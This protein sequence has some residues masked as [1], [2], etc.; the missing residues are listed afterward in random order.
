MNKTVYC[1][2]VSLITL[3]L[4]G[5]V[6]FAQKPL[7]VGDVL[8]NPGEK[9][10]GFIKVPKGMDG[11]EIQLPI[12]IINGVKDGPVLALTAGIHGYEYPPILALQRLLKQVEPSQI[13]GAVIMV[14]VVN[15]P[16]FLKRTTYYN[17]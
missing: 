6:A 10:S 9:K 7:K 13:S 11:P 8:A 14:H 17:P 16:S 12:T 2:V 4:I 5:N 3:C 1:T 15:M